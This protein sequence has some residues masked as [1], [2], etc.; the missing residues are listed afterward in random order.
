MPDI[1]FVHT[2]PLYC[3]LRPKKD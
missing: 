2:V 1:P 3:T